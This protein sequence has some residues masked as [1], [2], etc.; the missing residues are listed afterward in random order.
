MVYYVNQSFT[1]DRKQID[2]LKSC[3]F[4]MRESA[5]KLKRNSKVF[6]KQTSK[7]GQ[8]VETSGS[9]SFPLAM[10]VATTKMVVLFALVEGRLSYYEVFPQIIHIE[11]I[12]TCR[13]I[14]LFESFTHKAM[15]KQR[16][17]TVH[18]TS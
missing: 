10:Q 1:K 15:M 11:T 2:C 9:L 5:S 16:L 8:M 13:D 18:Q 14:T 3:T 7:M 17:I 6:N 12:S 4:V